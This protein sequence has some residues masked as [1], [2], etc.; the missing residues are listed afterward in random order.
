MGEFLKAHSDLSPALTGSRPL[1]TLSCNPC[2]PRPGVASKEGA[3]MRG[4]EATHA[5]RHT[6][7][8]LRG[9][10]NLEGFLEAALFGRR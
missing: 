1:H 3:H 9:K 8:R 4:E 5:T 7:E 10:H 2:P 6:Q